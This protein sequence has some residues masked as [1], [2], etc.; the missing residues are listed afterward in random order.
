MRYHR[1]RVISGRG[2]GRGAFTEALRALTIDAHDRLYAVGDSKLVVFSLEGKLL[3]T[4]P[5]E[6]PGHA[7]AVDVAG[8][9]YVGQPGQVQIFDAD[10]K[11]L[12]TWRDA[13]RMGLVTAIGF[14]GNS[15]ILA[16][17]RDRCLRRYEKSGTFVRNIGKDNRM[18]G[19]LIPNGYLDFVVDAD[20]IIHVCNPGKHRIERYTLDDKLLGH[21]GRFG[22]ND[23]V[24]F[25][26]CCNP[27]NVTLT[28]AGHVVVTTKAE[29]L[30]KIY[31][32]D[33]KLLALVGEN[34][35]D[36]NCKNMD[37]AVDSRGRIYVIDTA[38]LHICVFA[39]EESGS[40]SRPTGSTSGETVTP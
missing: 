6:R 1:Q 10:G 2:T 34:D 8:S 14:A 21:I 28:R 31:T 13:E 5:T 3:K 29:P 35:F 25:S 22:G 15:V 40:T 19:F 33:G 11:L 7:V 39:P 17:T 32:A 30:A 18:K 20:G 9:V 12:D 27:T 24:G 4:W 23:P 26:G 38:R 36:P 16:D 37:V